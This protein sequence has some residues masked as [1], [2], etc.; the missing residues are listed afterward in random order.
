MN[1]AA[2]ANAAY[3]NAEVE[4]LS[5][6]DLI[7]KLY[8][9]A[10]RSLCQAQVAMANK[11]FEL[12][13]NGCQRAKQIFIELLSTL[14]FEQGGEIAVQLRSLYVFLISRI[15]EANLVKDAK[16]ISELM[17]IIV[18]LREAWQQIPAELANV[19]SVPQANQ[20]HALNMKM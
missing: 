12:A 1:Q 13:Y 6:R 4:T 8:E 18:N 11:S 15:A 9:A 3:K 10:E 17:P 14:N 7:V 16:M 5:Q 20:G 2:Y 19:S